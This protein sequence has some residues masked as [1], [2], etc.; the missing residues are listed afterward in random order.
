MSIINYILS[1]FGHALLFLL[2]VLL[3][4][5]FVIAACQFCSSFLR[6][7]ITRGLPHKFFMYATASA[8][9][10]TTASEPQACGVQL[11]PRNS[12]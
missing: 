2:I 12:G 1:S 9:S 7:R 5:L 6:N 8:M 4:F 3:P 11:G 10:A